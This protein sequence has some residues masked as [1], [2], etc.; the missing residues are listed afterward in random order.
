ME[1]ESDAIKG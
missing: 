1:T